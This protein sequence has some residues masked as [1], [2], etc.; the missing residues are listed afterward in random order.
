MEMNWK[1]LEEIN[2]QLVVFCSDFIST[3][4]KQEFK[5]ETIEGGISRISATFPKA[6]DSTSYYFDVS[7][8]GCEF[9]FKNRE[10]GLYVEVLNEFDNFEDYFTEDEENGSA[11]ARLLR[12]K[13]H[14]TFAEHIDSGDYSQ[15]D[16]DFNV[17]FIDNFVNYI[18][19]NVY[20]EE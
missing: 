12:E 18:L 13:Y 10:K 15:L 19:N 2:P 5:I 1:S 7:S 16:E 17:Y 4:D 14:E 11:I 20:I 6:D 8:N 3:K 9:Y